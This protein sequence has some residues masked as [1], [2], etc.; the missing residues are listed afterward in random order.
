NKYDPANNNTRAGYFMRPK[1]VDETPVLWQQSGASAPIPVTGRA[2]TNIYGGQEPRFPLPQ[3]EKMKMRALVADLFHSPSRLRFMHKY[4]INVLYADG[5]A[6]FVNSK[7]F[8]N[9]P[10]TWPKPSWVTWSA[11][12][13]P[14]TDAALPDTVGANANGTMSCIW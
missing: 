2:Q 14:F 8:S 9:L 11:T 12:V 13:L 3:I 6:R 10:A 7:P 4:G 5:S 1:Y